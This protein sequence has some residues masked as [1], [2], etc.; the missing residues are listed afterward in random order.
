MTF[1]SRW[2]KWPATKYLKTPGTEIVFNWRRYCK[3]RDMLTETNTTA[4]DSDLDAAFS[5]F[6][7]P[8]TLPAPIVITRGA[9]EGS[10]EHFDNLKIVR[11]AHRA[12]RTA[13]YGKDER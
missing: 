11:A 3:V 7:A 6:D 13:R 1:L 10:A 12:L 2:Q 4:T 9:V 5:A 8:V